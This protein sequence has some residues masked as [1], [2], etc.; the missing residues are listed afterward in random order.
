MSNFNENKI[1]I[2]LRKLVIKAPP[3]AFIFRRRKSAD[4]IEF[5]RNNN[6]SGAFIIFALPDKFSCLFNR[7]YTTLAWSSLLEILIRILIP[8]QQQR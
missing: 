3:F 6:I 2:R 1:S 5:E 4:G 8:M 7:L